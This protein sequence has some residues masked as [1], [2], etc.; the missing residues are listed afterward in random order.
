MYSYFQQNLPSY[1]NNYFPL[2]KDIHSH[3]TRSAS[4]I[5]I[6]YKRTSY[7]KFSLKYRGAQIWNDIPAY[8]KTINSYHTFKKSIFDF[9]QKQIHF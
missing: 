2:N 3:D 7:G 8:L 1:F 9:V 6:D 4:K 5:H